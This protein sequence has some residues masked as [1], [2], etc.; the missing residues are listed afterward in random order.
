MK[1]KKVTILDIARKCG[2]SKSAVAY[3]LKDDPSYNASKESRELVLKTAKEMGY[4]PNLAARAL[5]S[6]RS[7][8]V[9]I[10]IPS[11]RDSY[12]VKLTEALL[13]LLQKRNYTGIIQSSSKSENLDFLLNR[14]VDGIIA[15]LRELPEANIPVAVYGVENSKYDSILFDTQT[16]VYEAVKYFY[17]LGHRRIAFAG[18]VR[19]DNQRIRGYR[20][21]LKELGLQ[22]NPQWVIDCSGYREF[23][24]T[25]MDKL[26]AAN[27]R[28]TAII[29]HNDLIALSAM[30]R[31]HE[32][33]LRLPQDLSVI[34]INNIPESETFIPA[35]TTYEE[36]AE[37]A[38][39][40]LIEM[41]FNR[42]E[43]GKGPAVHH[44]IKLPMLERESCAPPA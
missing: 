7:F 23:G 12:F 32:A 17:N 5:S 1:Q 29:A 28:P 38:A 20:T 21:A 10:V 13:I 11:F 9:G 36:S 30:R 42:I 4:R 14:S 33:G 15:C 18:N 44:L 19:P 22:E 6:R 35:L 8:T 39:T 37:D 3:I 25:A 26:L 41:L 40:K 27:E 2:I 24:I 31:A 34:G 16:A 43:G